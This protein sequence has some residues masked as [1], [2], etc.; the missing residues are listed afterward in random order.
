MK[1]TTRLLTLLMGVV[2][3]TILLPA[4][5]SASEY[6][7]P[8]LGSEPSM[9]PDTIIVQPKTYRVRCIAVPDES[10]SVS[11]MSQSYTE[12]E[13][14]TVNIRVLPGRSFT[15][16]LVDGQ[17]CQT[18]SSAFDSY[19]RT[20]S[21]VMPAHDVTVQAV[22]DDGQ[23]HYH[24]QTV[25]DP[26]EGGSIEIYPNT[27]YFLPGATVEVRINPGAGAYF[28]AFYLDG[29]RVSTSAS[30]FLATGRVY[31]FIMPDHNVSL[32]ATFTSQR[33]T[34][35]WLNGDGSVLESQSHDFAMAVRPRS[36]PTK[37]EDD[38]YTY[39]FDHWEYVSTEGWTITY[40]PV[41]T[42]V[43]K[44]RYHVVINAVPVSGGTVTGGG[45]YKAGV[46]VRL[47]AEANAGYRFAGWQVRSGGVNIVDDVFDMPECDVEIDA[48]FEAFPVEHIRILN[49]PED[50]IWTCYTG[51][52]F[53]VYGQMV[54]DEGNLATAVP[55]NVGVSW[56]SE[57]GYEPLVVEDGMFSYTITPTAA[58]N[59]LLKFWYDDPV[60]SV[61]F[62]IAEQLYV[63]ENYIYNIT[64][65]SSE[66][67]TVYA[68]GEELDLS[69]LFLVLHW[70]DGN[71]ER[72][73]V[74]AEMIETRFYSTQLGTQRLRLEY[75]Y[76]ET[77]NYPWTLFYEVQVTESQQSYSITFNTGDV[78]EPPDTS[79][80]QTDR[81]FGNILGESAWLE[82]TNSDEYSCQFWYLDPEL[83]QA[84]SYYT[85]VN[86]NVILYA[87]W[88][89]PKP[90]IEAV[91]LSI[92]PPAVG[93]S[94][95]YYYEGVEECDSLESMGISLLAP[96]GVRVTEA[97]YYCNM[98]YGAGSSMEDAMWSTFQ[99]GADYILV[100][101]LAVEEDNAFFKGHASGSFFTLTINESSANECIRYAYAG[102]ANVEYA[103]HIPEWNSIEPDFILPD[104]LMV[105]EE[106][107]FMQGAFRYVQLPEHAVRI[108]FRAF[109]NC[110]N[111]V[112]V[113][114]PEETNEIADDAFENVLGLAVIGKHGSFAETFARTHGYAFVPN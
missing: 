73:P 86:D 110:P 26:P 41:F 74:T 25:C 48:L 83:T 42:A 98:P 76:S 7:D 85:H 87:A 105:I 111:L 80:S 12:G 18:T 10:G 64:L 96:G 113:Y 53:T 8:S 4:A 35:V 36:T 32:R 67:K 69:N 6:F 106:E 75:R 34:T 95:P 47:G 103:F 97:Y 81:Y 68:W 78:C 84:A 11:V 62:S 28:S 94:L 91:A 22:F 23:P 56:D 55:G 100:L 5:A 9:I 16:L 82:P 108:G 33:R 93:A 45:G 107:A 3:L 66:A 24:V 89:G 46:V 21:F 102:F 72:I 39:E 19:R 37:A 17:E 44:P 51:K 50:G 61:L 88:D 59:F 54:D 63:V 104:S 109:A 101:N 99:P 52:P 38:E 20:A 65:D 57:T 40:R 79:Y 49:L 90:L 43:P 112:C 77:Y 30:P 27:H 60:S 58:G 14:V 31:S 114:I 2:L 70:A 15:K 1:I 29:E 92:A 71:E 13:L